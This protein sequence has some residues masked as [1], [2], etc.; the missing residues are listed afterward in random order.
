MH[1]RDDPTADAA[2]ESARDEDLHATTDSIRQRLKRLDAVETEKA[3]LPANDPRVDDLAEAAISEADRI[4]AE[5]RAERELA[6]D[7]N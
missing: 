7:A 4:A 1:D 5:T 3:S 6:E 2:R